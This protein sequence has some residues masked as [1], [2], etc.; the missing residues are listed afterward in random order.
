MNLRTGAVVLSLLPLAVTFLLAIPESVLQVR[1]NNATLDTRHTSLATGAARDIEDGRIDALVALRREGH[2]DPAAPA[3]FQTALSFM[4]TSMAHLQAQAR[5]NPVSLASAH[6]I[7]VSATAIANRFDAMDAQARRGNLTA[8]TA[9]LPPA[10]YDD[11]SNLERAVRTYI[12]ASRTAQ[13]IEAISLGR[14]LETSQLLLIFEFASLAGI[15]ALLLYFSSRAVRG[16]LNAREL[17]ERQLQRYRLLA[18]ITRD[19]ILFIDRETLTVIDANAAALAAY[20]YEYADFI[21][22]PATELRSGPALTPE[23]L[24]QSDSPAGLYLEATQLRSDGSTF[25]GEA[26]ARTAEIAGRQTIIVTIRDISER[27]QAAEQVA[28]ALEAAVAASRL[29]SEFVA[30]MSHE[31]RTPMHGVIAMSELLVEAD[32]SQPHSEYAATLKES[33]H[34]LLAIID[35]ILDFSKLEANKLELEAVAFDPARVVAGVTSISGAA[36]HGNG[37]SLS[38]T[39]SA[40]VP[41]TLRGD[42][43]RL[44]QILLNLV[45]NAV[46]FTPHGSV[47]IATTVEREEGRYFTLRFT[48]S[49]TG[50]GVAQNDRDRL[51]EAFVQGDG[52]TTRRFGGTGLGL[53][54]SRRLVE[55]MGGRIWLADHE[56]PGSTFCFTARFEADSDSV[57]PLQVTAASAPPPRAWAGANRQYRLLM[58]EDSPLIRRVARLQL[59]ELHF[60]V[61]MVENGLQAVAAAATGNYDLVLMDMRMPEMDG[62]AATRAIR[63]AERAGGGRIVVVA[64]TANVLE[65]DREACI[66]AGMD[67][68]LAKPLAL[69]M[70]RVMLERWLPDP[71]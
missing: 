39:V 38:S 36:A 27:H 3:A 66:A 22:K 42:P 15:S 2:R 45:G 57:V 34:A 6:Q 43:T 10:Y 52:T 19:I 54:I 59:E 14:L 21:G 29:K 69:D 60:P 5:P 31:I 18:E 68:F 58:A 8:L 70:L 53:S 20:R 67:D 35:D 1:A 71:Q 65:G 4:R 32:L 61:E 44:R 48:V 47:S 41:E 49:D 33:A 46:K 12:R 7:V 26:T 55:L 28:S 25:P 64:L 11:I 13:A 62:L 51:F 37:L 40:D 17:R 63:Q 24:K 50:I 9:V 16:I 23:L 56:G 30:T